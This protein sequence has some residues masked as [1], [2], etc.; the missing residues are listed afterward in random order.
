MLN[1]NKVGR[2]LAKIDG[3][4]YS[5][6]VVSVNDQFCTKEADSDELIS[7]FR[8]LKIANDSKFQHVPDT[9]KERE[10]L[11]ISGPSGSGKS[12]YTRKYLEQ[13]KKKFKNRPIY[14]FSSLPSDDSLDKIQPKRIKLDD[15][16]HTDPIKV[17]DLS[18]SICIFD[19][20]DVISNK[21]I[22]EAVYDILNQVLEIGR[23]YKIHC[24]VTNHLPTNGKDT[25]RILNEAHT[26]TYFPH[27]AG[28]KIKYMLEEYVGLDKKQIS[29]M[30]KQNSR[31]CTVFKNYPQCYMMEH[32][33]G[34]LNIHDD[35]SEDEKLVKAK[36]RNKLKEQNNVEFKSDVC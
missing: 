7:E 33:I 8:Q 18:E 21:K 28:G 19:D 27:S 31:W 30:K 14:L 16:L 3:G 32:E 2:P 11:Y 20:I 36:R 13:Y 17:D 5:G 12:T 25:R 9:T 15:T 34:L 6:R 23:H 29:Y 24:V 35:S 26:V 4:K 10:I 1:L 22:R